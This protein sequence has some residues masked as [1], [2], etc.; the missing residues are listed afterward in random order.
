MPEQINEGFPRGHDLVIKDGRVIDPETGLD[1]IRNIGIT[2]GSIVAV[3]Q[4]DLQGAVTIDASGLVVAPGWIDL[5]SHAQSVAGGRLQARDGVTT[6]L[7]LEGGFLG[8]AAHYE[9]AAT[10]GR[11][12]NY[13]FSTS[14]QAA[15]MV[16]VGGLATGDL[17]DAMAYFGNPAWK[18]SASK[19][20]IT[21]MVARLGQDIDDGAI[22][23]G[24]LMG[25][26]PRV[27]PSEYLTMA[28]L[29]ADTDTGTF[30]HARDLVEDVPD[31][32]IDGAEEIV[33]AAQETGARSHY[34]HVNSTSAWH[35]DRVHDL[36]QRAQTEITTE[37]YPY[38]AASTSITAD[39]LSPDRLHERGL[40]PQSIVYTPTGQRVAD[41]AMLAELQRRDPGAIAIVHFLNESD[42]LEQSILDRALLFPGTVVGSDA[43]PLIW[44]QERHDPYAWP[45][46]DVTHHPRGAGSFSR[47]LRRYVRELGAISLS[48]A[49]SRCALGPARV[50]ESYVP[51]MRRKGRV[52]PGCDA[53]LVVFDPENV[54]D[55]ATYAT[56]TLPSTGYAYVLVGGQV[57]V[58]HDQLRLDVLPGRPVRSH[59][60]H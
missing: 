10:E 22:G 51:A 50:L 8:V 47:F 34:C 49:V 15:R 57:L 37:A 19:R 38:G 55:R 31:T 13:G 33:N 46:A 17:V 35:V 32:V 60:E 25:Y 3:T 39:F 23:L 36:V 58:D 20:Q 21:A 11:A 44:P 12:I 26:A 41:D 7:D 1:G 30:T 43:M 5:H 2:K 45:P 16:D 59:S 48:E 52:Q 53:D 24:L 18:V 6:A 27:E 9:R 54:T 56:G 29:A 14:W 28:Q 42:P 4:D 40:T